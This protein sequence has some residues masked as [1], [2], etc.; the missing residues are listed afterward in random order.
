MDINFRLGITNVLKKHILPRISPELN[1]FTN[2]FNSYE[3]QVSTMYGGYSYLSL[4]EKLET[5]ITC[6]KI[7][8]I[9]IDADLSINCPL[10]DTLLNLNMIIINKN[11]DITNIIGVCDA[12]CKHI[13]ESL[14]SLGLG[15]IFEIKQKKSTNLFNGITIY[16]T[17][18]RQR[19]GERITKKRNASV[20]GLDEEEDFKFF[21]QNIQNYSMFTIDIYTE[22]NMN[23]E[24][25][26]KLTTY[27]PPEAAAAAAALT[28]PTTLTKEGFIILSSFVYF[29]SF[30]DIQIN[31]KRTDDII[32]LFLTQQEAFDSIEKCQI[33]FI[34][35]PSTYTNKTSFLLKKFLI[36]FDIEITS[37][38]GKSLNFSVFES[39]F[40]TFLIKEKFF[41]RRKY[42]LRQ[43]INSFMNETD[44]QLIEKNLG[45][46]LKTGGE[47]FRLYSTEQITNDIDTKIFL[48]DITQRNQKYIAENIISSLFFILDSINKL[49]NEKIEIEYTFTF[50]GK[51]YKYYI[52]NNEK[53]Y[54]NISCNSIN[55]IQLSFNID[56]KFEYK[57]NAA[58]EPIIILDKVFSS[59]LD[60]WIYDKIVKGNFFNPDPS[61]L[62]I[63]REYFIKDLEMS[64][65]LGGDINRQLR[66]YYKGKLKKDIDRYNYL[67]A[68]PQVVA[69]K[70][71]IEEITSFSKMDFIKNIVEK[72]WMETI[73]VQEIK[74][75]FINYSEDQAKS[76]YFNINKFIEGRYFFIKNI[77]GDEWR[78]K[79]RENFHNFI[80]KML[81]LI[82]KLKEIV[83]SDN[84]VVINFDSFFY[85][86]NQLDEDNTLCTINPDDIKSSDINYLIWYT[87]NTKQYKE[88]NEK[89]IKN[90]DK[91]II[92]KPPDGSD[93]EDASEDPD[94]HGGGD[95]SYIESLI[96][97]KLKYI[98][99]L[100]T[101]TASDEKQIILYK[102]FKKEAGKEM[103]DNIIVNN[104]F[105]TTI[106]KNV[107]IGFLDGKKCCIIKIILKSQVNGIYLPII[108]VGI[109][110]EK[111]VLLSPS[112]LLKKKQDLTED[113]YK[114]YVYEYKELEDLEKPEPEPEPEQKSNIQMVDAS[115]DDIKM[116]VVD[117]SGDD[118]KMQVDASGDDV[119]HEV[120]QKKIDKFDLLTSFDRQ[121]FMRKFLNEEKCTYN[122]Y[123]VKEFIKNVNKNRDRFIDYGYK[124]RFRGRFEQLFTDFCIKYLKDYWN[125]DYN[126]SSLINSTLI[127]EKK[128]M[129]EQTTIRQLLNTF[130]ST[131]NCLLNKYKY[132]RLYKSGGESVR[133]YTKEHGEQAT[134]DI[135]SK[136][137]CLP[138]K[139]PK[140]I[141]K[142]IY[143]II[144][145][146]IILL[147]ESI[148]KNNFTTE[149][150]IIPDIGYVTSF[151]DDK[152]TYIDNYLLV[153]TNYV[154]KCFPPR[155]NEVGDGS[156]N[157]KDCLNV[158]SIDIN[159][160]IVLNP[161]D[162]SVFEGDII[163]LYM[164]T[165]PYDFLF[166]NKACEDTD[167]R[168][169]GDLDYEKE[170][171]CL[172]PLN[173]PL[174]SLHFIISDLIGLLKP[175]DFIK[176]HPQFNN[177]ESD[178]ERRI[179]TGKHKKDIKRY[180]G[181]MKVFGITEVYSK[182]TP[183]DTLKR[184]EQL[185]HIF[186]N[187]RRYDID[188]NT[189]YTEKLDQKCDPSAAS[190]VIEPCLS[191]KK[192][193]ISYWNLFE[194]KKLSIDNPLYKKIL[195]NSSWISEILDEQPGENRILHYLDL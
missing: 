149:E 120:K 144:S 78:R 106:N 13:V 41:D 70:K 11:E 99:D 172:L 67:I 167:I 152:K 58:S 44:K 39:D 174:A 98:L 192:R 40:N 7:D 112:F 87:S 107:S 169:R 65:P 82:T 125:I 147:A 102:G 157:N 139:D 17:M 176:Q 158:I 20:A 83:F 171:E 105:S 180:E 141:K 108:N 79:F 47:A 63:S 124:N 175:S 179:Q 9:K 130:V 31:K 182:D 16:I 3:K 85:K 14:E 122:F 117:A 115:G 146:M 100:G 104:F 156:K 143:Q 95:L 89:I 177:F 170:N 195:E 183:E 94:E 42:S 72:I 28:V 90:T 168:E 18:S 134:N 118:I 29:E 88:L 178:L 43:I 86:H 165:S 136:F 194:T 27:I 49:D 159:N 191:L 55:L 33:L 61:L 135:D 126:F 60:I 54:L 111:E 109:N 186:E 1:R 24:S 93:D 190:A 166:T 45:R 193:L 74:D 2:Y 187:L 50:A 68:N 92:N 30:N 64:L 113:G 51:K 73:N 10:E 184:I 110:F 162:T 129:T 145:I 155:Q 26:K 57:L 59:P 48:K 36:K 21:D 69:D 151:K 160:R 97:S 25:F 81:L 53:D 138:G 137:C 22:Q 52:K 46:F 38:L 140:I 101:I 128:S 84:K 181:F 142:Q 103:P 127:L 161:S 4:M 188:P 8:E 119:K 133:Y 12:L 164:N 154:G 163:N 114:I 150:Y 131:I 123:E 80:S 189:K 121:K 19:I 66:R 71:T 6:K 76:L 56:S 96:I 77:F 173:P 75:N 5:E 35:Y 32:N 132:G 153:R 34:D 15:L 37:A 185:N 148:V 116:Q 62:F 23:I 91:K